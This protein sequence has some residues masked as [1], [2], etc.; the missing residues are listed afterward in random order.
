[1]K[2]DNLPLIQA[3]KGKMKPKGEEPL[4]Q[5]EIPRTFEVKHDE[6]PGLPGRPVGEA[7]SVRLEGHVHSQHSDGHAIMHV[8]SVKPDTSGIE[9]KQYPDQRVP[10]RGIDPVRMKTK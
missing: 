2:N 7:M 3:L 8:D 9:K 6:I 5:F 10:E 4:A 1:M